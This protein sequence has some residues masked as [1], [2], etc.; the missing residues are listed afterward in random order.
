MSHGEYADRTDGQTD[1]RQIVTL[2]LLLDTTSLID[3]TGQGYDGIRVEYDYVCY[4]WT[5]VVVVRYIT[6]AYTLLT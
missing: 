5:P 2:R 6:G 1:G 4:Y 3:S